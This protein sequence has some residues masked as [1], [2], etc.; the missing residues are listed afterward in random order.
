MYAGT[1]EF[2]GGKVEGMEYLEDCLVREVMEEV[3]VNL[4]G[5]KLE[6]A[7][8]A[9]STVKYGRQIIMFLFVCRAP[10]WHVKARE[11]QELQWA[12][13]EDFEDDKF[14]FATLAGDQAKWLLSRLDQNGQLCD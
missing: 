13:K 12:S 11:C 10:S 8:F 14:C 7:M 9:A 4:H 3:G 1:W 2:P 5:K 6:P